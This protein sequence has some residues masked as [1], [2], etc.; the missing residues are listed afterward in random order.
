MQDW[1]QDLATSAPLMP[2]LVV[3]GALLISGFGFPMPED[4]PLII[5]DDPVLLQLPE[6]TRLLMDTGQGNI[7]I[8]ISQI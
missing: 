1:L 6:T 3:L 7:Y 2:Y 8:R 4:I 5:A